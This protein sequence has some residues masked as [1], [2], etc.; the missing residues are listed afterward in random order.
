[1]ANMA[2]GNAECKDASLWM[3][4]ARGLIR[5]KKEGLKTGIWRAASPS[6]SALILS[7][8]CQRWI[9][10]ICSYEH[11][12]QPRPEREITP[13][14]EYKSGLLKFLSRDVDLSSMIDFNAEYS[15]SL[16]FRSS[17]HHCPVTQVN[18]NVR[19]QPCTEE[20]NQKRCHGASKKSFVCH[21]LTCPA[22]RSAKC[23]S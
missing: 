21:A 12:Q 6:Y 16:R 20:R 9:I 5:G 19:E 4:G 10:P 1:M 2:C 17:G 14:T 7:F 23:C 18:V 13:K 8:A 11:E 22:L 15:A 3:W